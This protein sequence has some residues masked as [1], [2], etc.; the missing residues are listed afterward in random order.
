M[1]R[2]S[3]CGILCVDKPWGWT[4]HDIVA[5]V[6]RLARQRQVGHAG[7]LDPRA[8]GLLLVTVGSATRLSEYLMHAGK[9]YLARVCLGIRTSTDDSEGEVLSRQ[10]ADTV[11]RADVRAALARFTG[12]IQQVPPAY[13]AIKQAGL[14]AYQRARQGQA[15]QMAPRPVRI[16]ALAVVAMER[17][18]VDLLVWCGAGTYIRALAHDLGEALGCGGHLASLRR[19]SSGGFAVDTAYSPAAL[20]RLTA[21]GRLQEACHAL[22][23]AVAGWPALLLDEARAAAVVHGNTVAGPAAPGAEGTR[24]YARNGRLLALA[25]YEPRRQA[26]QPDRVVAQSPGRDDEDSETEHSLSAIVDQLTGTEKPR[27]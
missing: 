9:C 15:P 4:S 25:R 19:L 7:T 24:L 17:P 8:T 16:D 3:I 11:T 5:L 21:E 13:S 26:W 14:P 1:S 10:P 23:E 22:D 12:T 18:M 2:E 6:R 20:R 27:A